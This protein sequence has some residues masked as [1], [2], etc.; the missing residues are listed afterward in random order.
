[1]LAWSISTAGSIGHLMHMPA[2][3]KGSKLSW[4]TIYALQSIIGAQASGCLGQSDWTRYA[5]THNA[6]LLGQLVAAPILICVTA[7]CGL[8]ITSAT[9][10]LYG[11]A[12]WNPFELLLLIQQRSL[13]PAARAGT[14]FAGDVQRIGCD[15]AAALTCEFQA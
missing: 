7:V 5:K 1:M 15:S 9:N 2:T 8:L 14:F 12:T 13:S 10:D 11:V 4:A 3:V 6:A